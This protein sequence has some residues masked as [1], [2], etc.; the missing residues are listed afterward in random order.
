MQVEFVEKLRSDKDYPLVVIPFYKGEK[1][2]VEVFT[3][4]DF[5]QH[6]EP[7]VKLRDFTGAKGE[8]HF[9]YPINGIKRLALLGIGEK[10]TISNEDLRQAFASLVKQVRKKKIKEA[11]FLLST[12]TQEQVDAI[13]DGIL[14]MNYDFHL[15]K[16]ESFLLEKI[17]FLDKKHKSLFTHKQKL[18]SGVYLARDLVNEN[19]DQVTP[20]FL[21]K[22]A[23][24][25]AA[26][27]PAITTTVL[28]KKQIEK[29][30]MGLL[31]AVN[32]ASSI[33]PRLVLID[34]KGGKRGTKPVV[35]VGKGVTYDTG[36]LSL[37]PT[38]GMVDMKA[39]MGGAATVL[40]TMQ[41]LAELGIKKNVIGVIPATENS[42]DANSYKPGDVY[43][44]LSGKTVEVNNTDAEGRLIL[45]D[46]MEYANK[47]LDPACII[48]LATLTGG[49]LVALGDEISG[50]F[51]EQKSLL[52][53]FEKASVKT[54]EPIW[55]MPLYGSYKKMLKSEIADL[56]NSAGR[57][58]AA[59]TAALFLREFV[60]KTPW[61][62]FDIA[63]PAFYE[64]PKG[65][66][67]S[68]A[69]GV[70]VRLLIEFLQSYRQ[71]G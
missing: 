62:H 69:T 31:L 38:H 25:L 64:K 43:R 26:T 21:A 1:Q 70:G 6:Y 59:I 54:G 7:A 33:D 49:I 14:S 42:I 56:V 58:A 30:Q 28:E 11:V 46:A 63:G 67:S 44:S 3:L 50:I 8:V 32:R 9:I 24:G 51:T 55:P 4:I 39:D 61:V 66:C 35:L 16:K 71:D 68:Q 29:E 23:K 18:F 19:A 12:F 53:A 52:K 27:F 15:Y 65:I 45:A 41:A 17:T 2:A 48:D 47:Y 22:T 57:N 37:K 20:S 34:Y 10:K 5:T 36:G 40:G 60:D 13:F